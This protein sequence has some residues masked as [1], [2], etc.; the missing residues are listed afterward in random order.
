MMTEEITPAFLSND[1]E[2]QGQSDY[3]AAAAPGMPSSRA[4]G[5]GE[6][7]KAGGEANPKKAMHSPS[8]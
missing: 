7:W 8:H 4:L 6:K 1:D 5:G 3:V 2:H